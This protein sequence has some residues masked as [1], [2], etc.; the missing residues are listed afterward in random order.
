MDT[1][2]FLKN[3]TRMCHSGVGGCFD[4]KLWDIEKNDCRVLSHGDK[5]YYENTIKIVE[6]FAVGHPAKT[7]QSEFLK[8]YP[9]AKINDGMIDICPAKMCGD[10]KCEYSTLERIKRCSECHK[11]YWLSEIE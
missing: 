9:R 7:R 11:D 5:K 4:C 1:V 6:E 2:N 3:V 8:M 10:V